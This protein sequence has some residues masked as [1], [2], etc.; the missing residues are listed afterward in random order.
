M[1]ITKPQMSP[2]RRERFLKVLAEQ[3]A[4]SHM[5][6]FMYVMERLTRCDE[7]LD[8]LIKNRITGSNFLAFVK[9][10]KLTPLSLAQLI[11]RLI[12]KEQEVRPIVYGKDF[13]G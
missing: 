12:A 6:Y 9:E 4:N 3:T 7:A 1:L 11:F 2:E 10:Y 13:Q 8:W 5:L